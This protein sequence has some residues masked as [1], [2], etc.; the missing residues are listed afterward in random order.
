[1]YDFIPAGYTK[2]QAEFDKLVEE[3]A[4]K[5]VPLGGK[6]GSYKLV[7]PAVFSKGKGKAKASSDRWEIVNVEEDTEKENENEDGSTFEVYATTW[8]TPGFTDYHRRMQIFVLLYIEGASYI[9]EDDPRWEFLTLFVHPRCLRKKSF[10]LTSEG[11][12]SNESGKAT[13]SLTI[14]SVIPPFIPSFVGQTRND[15][16]SRAYFSLFSSFIGGLTD[17]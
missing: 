14:L 10:R 1:L 2:V 5:F 8:E 6:I 13:E 15:Y 16:V 12:G 7:T 3:E 17:P 9:E 11:A 4:E